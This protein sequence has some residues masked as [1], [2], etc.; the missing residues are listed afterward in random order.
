[1]EVTTVFFSLTG[2][3]QKIALAIE[4]A[5]RQDGHSVKTTPLKKATT[6]DVV[7]S[8]LL[9][10]GGPC[11][12]NQ[13][14]TPIKDFIRRLP[15]LNGLK[16]FVFAT[17][18]GAPGRVL[19]SM[20]EL[21]HRK[22]ADVIG[23]FLSRGELFYPAP[24]MVGRF[25]GRPDEDDLK[26][27]EEFARAISEHIGTSRT[28]PLATSRPDALRP[29]HGIYDVIGLIGSDSIT[30][31]LTPAPRLDKA[32]C[33]NCGRCAGICPMDN[34]TQREYP[35]TG[36]RC[37]RCYGCVLDC[38]QKAFS[39]DWRIGNPII[40]SLYNSTFEHWLGDL[41]PGED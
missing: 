29:G 37:I 36:K 35:Q 2:N 31:L 24:S 5:F 26:K 8:D 22:G 6:N 9:G 7:R 18:G 38:P 23:G 21:L 12:G 16:T 27:A 30:R 25:A 15:Q 33:D 17:S 10:I 4:K 20:T 28:G 41:G 13:A 11:Y 32:L 39:L 40:Y 1:M 3:T 19:F 34:I 14:P